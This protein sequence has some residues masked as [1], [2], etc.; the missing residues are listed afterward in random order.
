MT[1]AVGFVGRVE[2]ASVIRSGVLVGFRSSGG[3]QS[4]GQGSPLSR[5][6]Q[7]KKLKK[8]AADCQTLQQTQTTFWRVLKD[9]YSEEL[10][11]NCSTQ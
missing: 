3:E 7:E 1:P 10:R 5:V 6:L 8:P 9:A 2:G 11:D 4:D